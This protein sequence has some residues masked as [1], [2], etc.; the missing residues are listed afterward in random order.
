[1]KNLGL[2]LVCALFSVQASAALW[3]RG[4]GLIYD[5]V[6]DITW[7]QDANY[8]DTSGFHSGLLSWNEA[9][10]FIDALNNNS[11]LGI[12][13]WRLPN[14]DVDGDAVMVTCSLATEVECR[15]NELGY[16]SVVYGAEAENPLVFVNVQYNYWS[17]TD[18]DVAN[19]T[20]PDGY[21]CSTGQEG[22]CA[23]RQGFGFDS[24]NYV[25]KSFGETDSR[26]YSAW[27][28]ASGD[29]SAVI[30][31]DLSLP[32]GNIQE[33]TLDGFASVDANVS[34]TVAPDDA[35]DTIDW[36]LDDTIVEDADGQVVTIEVPL[37]S[38]A[39]EA[40]VSTILGETGSDSQTI[41]V[42]DT[43]PPNI[44]ASLLDPRSG[45]PI[46]QLGRKDVGEV[47]FTVDDVCDVNPVVTASVG[48]PAANGDTVKA[49]RSKKSEEIVVKIE[50]ESDTV[51]LIVTAS[52]SSGNTA[53]TRTSVPVTD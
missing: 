2:V 24:Q 26:G 5:D 43:V 37:G 36:Y 14:M 40:R 10:D 38:H 30:D 15:D 22:G 44:T 17:S 20:H 23:W 45:L 19:V 33:C 31:V 9:N 18:Y 21:P 39:I 47:F 13:T 46:N 41:V 7:L 42:E 27:A 51:E 12:D 6:L 50:G 1:M 8:A 49:S 25:R 32:A 53:T 29:V 16:M 4:N 3:D 48:V 34:I 28:V 35:I 52:D 11:H